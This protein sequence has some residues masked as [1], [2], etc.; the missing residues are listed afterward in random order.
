MFKNNILD[1]LVH[2]LNLFQLLGFG[3]RVGFHLEMNNTKDKAAPLRYTGSG[4]VLEVGSSKGPNRLGVSLHL[5]E[6]GNQFPKRCAFYLFRIP[7]E[8]K[9]HKLG[10][11]ELY[12]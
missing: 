12:C 4:P 8:D 3:S 2:R 6:D 7:D 1:F 5:S 10:D 11:S 9:V